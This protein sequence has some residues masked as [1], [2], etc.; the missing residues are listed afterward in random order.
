[1]ARRDDTDELDRNPSTVRGKLDRRGF[2]RGG[3]AML[4]AMSAAGLL[5]PVAEP[6]FGAELAAA[7]GAS[8]T[9][10]IQTQRVLR[11]AGPTP[12]DWVRPRNG[13]DHNVVI[14]GGGQT[15]LSIAY[16]LRR[17]GV[18]KV[19]LIE[20]APAGGAGIWRD[21]ARMHQ[22]RTPKMLVGPEQ[23]NTALGFRAWYETLNGP[24]AFEGLDRI[25]RL[26]WADYL[27]WYEQIS[28]AQTRYRTR[29]VDIEP[30][31]DILRLHLEVD[32]MPRTETT[33]KL[34]LANGY[35]GAGG[36]SVPGFI[37][38][39]PAQKWSHTE[40]PINFD[41]LK[42]KTVGVLGAGASAFDAAG[43]ALEH[44][45]AAVHL[46]SRRPYIEYTNAPAGAVPAPSAP[47]PPA[48]R[49]H[50]NLIEFAYALPDDV[51]WRN[52]VGRERSVATVP[53]DSMNRAVMHDN[54]FLHVDAPWDSVA[55]ESS[56]VAVKSHGTTHRFDYVISGTGYQIDIAAQPEFAHIHPAVALWRDRF[57]PG[58][59]ED[60]KA[61]GAYPYLGLGFEFLPREGANAAYL[62]NIHC[63]NLAAAASFGIL[64]GDVPS[65][66]LQ[67][68]LVSA[69]AR[70]LFAEGVDTAVNKRFF[71]MPA[72]VPNPAPYQKAI[73]T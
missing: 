46:F 7:P 4:G 39:L 49:G 10:S 8:E 40:K 2:F 64:V 63:V 25:P 59:G 35:N 15:G 53:F 66:V 1:M 36:A 12:A 44:G 47:R 68:Q 50:A 67:P 34:V 70:D 28:G 13:V 30:E 69:I 31:G 41:A 24:S 33:R 57:K 19:V 16:A 45:A 54:F 5:R 18:G 43:V 38:S 62:R 61:S 37:R 51:R 17:K 23:G 42:G 9:L 71:E 11:W 73:H 14:V 52:Q 21:I 32:G 6:A 22:L 27:S 20:Q 3:A 58:A 65:M 48:D 26:A 29:L 60:D 55:M 56:K 72:A